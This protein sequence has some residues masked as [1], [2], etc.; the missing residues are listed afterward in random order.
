MALDYLSCSGSSAAPE[1]TLLAAADIRSAVKWGMIPI[2]I[3][4][5]VSTCMWL[6]KGVY[7]IN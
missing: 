1:R 7:L 6:V 4:T 2:T 3:E 5:A